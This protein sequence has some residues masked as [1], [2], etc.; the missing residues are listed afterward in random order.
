MAWKPHTN[1]TWGT[2][3]NDSARCRL[4]FNL[5]RDIQP[6]G[7]YRCRWYIA[8]HPKSVKGKLIYHFYSAVLPIQDWSAY[9]GNAVKAR[10][11]MYTLFW[12]LWLRIHSANSDAPLRAPRRVA[13]RCLWSGKPSTRFCTASTILWKTRF[14]CSWNTRAWGGR[15][16]LRR[17]LWKS[18]C[19]RGRWLFIWRHGLGWRPERKDSGSASR[20]YRLLHYWLRDLAKS[21]ALQTILRELKR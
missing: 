10:P 8:F 20:V 9:A 18:E 6:D 14:S 7:L 19:H 4:R 11:C 21:W 5:K 13:G 2:Y 16:R 1:Q 17:C 12:Q 3:S 15:F